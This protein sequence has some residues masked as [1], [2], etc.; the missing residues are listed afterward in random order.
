MNPCG[1]WQQQVNSIPPLSA[2]ATHLAPPPVPAPVLSAIENLLAH[3]SADGGVQRAVRRV[4]T[5]AT[6]AAAATS[7]RVCL[8]THV[9]PII[10]NPDSVFELCHT[11]CT[12]VNR[13]QPCAAPTRPSQTPL[14][15]P[16]RLT[17]AAVLH[18][19]LL[20]RAIHMVRMAMSPL[21]SPPKTAAAVSQCS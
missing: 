17:R 5:Q 15:E 14:T 11:L 3:P 19:R 10:S 6:A 18:L 1:S 2:E 7:E 20:L 16:P 8:L 21:G 13:C 4:C 12:S 9:V